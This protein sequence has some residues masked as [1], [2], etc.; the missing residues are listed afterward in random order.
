MLLALPL[1]CNFALAQHPVY[2]QFTEENGLPDVEFYDV[3]QDSHGFFWFAANN[4]LFRYDGK[5]FKNYNHP[6]KRGLSV[7]NLT[8]DAQGNIWCVNISG[9]LFRVKNDSLTIVADLNPSLTIDVPDYIFQ[10][11]GDI[12]ITSLAGLFKL[13][14]GQRTL[15]KIKYDGQTN[16]LRR[17]RQLNNDIYLIEGHHKLLK[18]HN[19]E[20]EPIIDSISSFSEC[21]IQKTAKGIYL[22]GWSD[23]APWKSQVNSYDEETRRI[24]T[25]QLPEKLANSKILSI[26]SDSRDS[27]WMCTSRGGYQVTLKKNTFHINKVLL[28][29]TF[30]TKIIEDHE[31]HFWLTTLDKGIFFIPNLEVR[32]YTISK[33][34]KKN[35]ITNLVKD[36]R[37]SVFYVSKDSIFGK[38]GKH[39]LL[40]GF[41][42]PAFYVNDL[43]YNA[44]N[45]KFYAYGE[46]IIVFD[47]ATIAS[48]D[49][50]YI[51]TIKA[52]TILPEDQVLLSNNLFTCIMP[53]KISHPQLT[54]I[55][56]LRGKRS[57]ANYY[58]PTSGVIYT[59]Y[60]DGVFSYEDGKSIEIK[61]KG[62]DIHALGF[63]E[64]LDATVWIATFS[65]GVLGVR[66]NQVVYEFNISNGLKSNE[67][68]KVLADHNYLWIVHKKGLQSIDLT[69]NTI[70][71][72]DRHDGL[73]TYSISDIEIAGGYV[74]LATPEG[75]ISLPATHDFTNMVP[76]II[77]V[78]GLTIDEV[79]Q[80]QKESYLLEYDNENI[81]INFNSTSFSPLATQK[82][83]LYKLE[84]VDNDWVLTTSDYARYPSI[85]D[86]TYTFKVKALNE[87]GLSS[88]YPATL[89]INV[90]LPLWKKWWFILL[91]VST[92]VLIVYLETDRIMKRRAVKRKQQQ[93]KREIEQSLI[94]S[95]LTAL[96]SQM[97]PHF[98]FNALNSIQEHIITNQRDLASDYLGKFADLMRVYLDQ[99]RRDTI[100]LEDE[101]RTLSLYLGLE[102]MRFEENF[103]YRIHTSEVEEKMHLHIP[104]LLIQPYTE[105]AIKHGLLH[106]RG[107]K[108]LDIHFRLATESPN[109][110]IC[111]IEDNGVGRI[112]SMQINAQDRKNHRSF[113]LEA[114][115]SRLELLNYGRDMKIG[116]NIE[117][118]YDEKT[119]NA[120]GTRVILRIPLS[121][122]DNNLDMKNHDTKSTDH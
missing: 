5:S 52:L 37:D 19:G 20:I 92:L 35:E 97:N 94:I 32:L 103:E 54:D 45:H 27:L 50:T 106:K 76:P 119:G 4:G 53:A 98:L 80:P 38:V 18:Y 77:Y 122:S 58:S 82:Q 107:R 101:V 46:R 70:A 78:E 44:S 68:V 25:L 86:G 111:I 118:L 9:Q 105:N 33:A 8:E 28:P 114:G 95:Q 56:I 14:N 110:L 112:R 51:N 83:F 43:K 34:D 21:S 71:T 72:I 26:T 42:I 13:K 66:D 2:Y 62:N 48:V 30:V 31:K 55:R 75:I 16:R 11:N 87:D 88:V 116:V 39:G 85:P 100:T 40:P 49:P 36:H 47:S 121:A 29:E 22:V 3:I 23:F 15:E 99:S 102:K 89:T 7:F 6:G 90:A 10:D 79:E 17:I 73:N 91:V 67:I 96:R 57:Y 24:T 12:L 74:Y 104:T 64:T 93:E 81:R 69:T 108:K 117:D 113:A 1:L 120:L 41:K 60:V 63:S 84:G 61:F 109:V 115:K 65:H 59:G